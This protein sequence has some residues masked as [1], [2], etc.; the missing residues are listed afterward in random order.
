MGLKELIA[1]KLAS[2]E[3]HSFTL[4]K[5]V[6]TTDIPNG[7]ALRFELSAGATRKNIACVAAW[8]KMAGAGRLNMYRTVT[9][10]GWANAGGFDRNYIT[11]M[12]DSDGVVSAW[13]IDAAGYRGVPFSD[14][15]ALDMWE[16]PIIARNGAN[17]GVI[18][19]VVQNDSGAA[20][21]YAVAVQLVAWR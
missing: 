10:G 20:A 1:A 9:A 11:E 7:Q 16:C 5:M 19:G 18:Q 2:G 8:V 21:A 17:N 6:S 12:L 15:F 14:V 4:Q 13:E 3:A